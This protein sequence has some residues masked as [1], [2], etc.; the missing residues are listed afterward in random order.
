MFYSFF[1]WVSVW[2]NVVKWRFE[3]KHYTDGDAAQ[4]QRRYLKGHRARNVAEGRQAD[5]EG[6]KN[7]PAL[8]GGGWLGDER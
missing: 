8:V 2:F 3:L 7:A 4:Q 5:C 1:Q 6:S